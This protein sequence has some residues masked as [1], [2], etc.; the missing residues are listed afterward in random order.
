MTG[1]A[2]WRVLVGMVEDIDKN[3]DTG[4]KEGKTVSKWL[5]PR[6]TRHSQVAQNN[7]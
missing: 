5:G 2:N 6:E 1:D 4:E 7:L 3:R